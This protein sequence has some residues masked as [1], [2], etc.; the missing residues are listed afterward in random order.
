M[1]KIY[2]KCHWANAK[3]AHRK[4]SSDRPLAR[5]ANEMLRLLHRGRL[6]GHFDFVFEPLCSSKIEVAA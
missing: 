3:K 5:A 1:P 6:K 4:I 2:S